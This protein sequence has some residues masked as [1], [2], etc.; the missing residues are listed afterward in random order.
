M[1]SQIPNSQSF[2]NQYESFWT[3]LYQ[4]IAVWNNWKPIWE[5]REG[6]S[7]LPRREIPKHEDVLPVQNETHVQGWPEDDSLNESN[8]CTEYLDFRPRQH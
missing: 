4:N 1:A 7:L 8:G 6:I 2:I 5:K 3:Y